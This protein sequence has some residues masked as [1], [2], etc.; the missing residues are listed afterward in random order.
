MGS[1]PMKEIES[2]QTQES[3]SYVYVREST[4]LERLIRRIRGAERVAVDTD[5]YSL[6][7]YL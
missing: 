7:N 1:G 6:Y 2:L 4:V 5:S 3:E